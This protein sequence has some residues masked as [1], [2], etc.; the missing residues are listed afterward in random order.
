MPTST[1]PERL[2]RRAVALVLAAAVLALGTACEPPVL[3]RPVPLPAGEA[4]FPDPSVLRVG[5]QYH[6]FATNSFGSPA[7]NV[8]VT[9]SSDLYAWDQVD[10]ALPVVPDW[11]WTVPEGGEFWAPSAAAFGDRYVL[12][13]SARHRAVPV[14]EPG[15]CVGYAVATDPRGPY[16][17]GSQPLL[18]RVVGEGAARV[19]SLDPAA[20][21][22]VIDP[23]VF[24][25]PDGSRF[26]HL[27][28]L[29]D[30]I[31]L[32]GIA[33]GG[34]GLVTSGFAR[35]MVTLPAQADTWEYAAQA[36]HGFTILE[37]PA[38]DLNPDA[39]FTGF[40]YYLFYAGGDWRTSTYAT[41]VAAC[42][43][44][45][46]PCV[47]ATTDAPWLSSTDDTR[48]PGG[49]SVFRTASGE[50]W[51]A[52]HS[53]EAGRP[54]SDGRRLH[55]E[56]LRYEGIE[57]V[58][59]DRPPVGDFA[60]LPGAG[61]VLFAGE[62]ADPDSGRPPRVVVREGEEVVADVRAGADGSYTA[63]VD[64]RP[65]RHHYCGAVLDDREDAERNLFCHVVDVPPPP[66]ASSPGAP[67]AG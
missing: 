30:P 5:D 13:F 9:T 38:M 27:K 33:L 7:R 53:W 32:W 11:A 58:L 18:C 34:T 21:E 25:A 66:P 2:A 60:L 62:A 19:P 17:P 6:A 3:R 40:P 23:Q 12:Y 61:G 4:N 36:P 46:G 16:T 57:P 65:G 51:V 43:G 22:G 63:V 50:R 39:A 37:N 26:L 28:V 20:G 45:L 15:W 35:G 41:G 44:P 49:L 55:V 67:G 24:V 29:D 47:R 10:D 42:Q 59:A 48:G 54:V 56:P 31:Q 14:D 52:Y 1:R 8:Q 64:A